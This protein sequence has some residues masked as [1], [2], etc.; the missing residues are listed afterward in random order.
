M[1]RKNSILLVCILLIFGTFLPWGNTMASSGSIVIATDMVNVRSGPGLSYSLVKQAKRGEKYPV[2][3]EKGDWVQIQLSTFKTGWVVSWLIAKENGESKTAVASSRNTKAKAITEQLRV[4]SGPGTS[5]QI[6]GLLA[7]GEE[8]QILDQNENWY[9]IDTQ[10]GE[11]WASKE[12]FNTSTKTNN[13]T[14]TSTT[15]LGRVNVDLLNVREEPSSKSTN[16][17]KLTK[18]T[19]VTI[20]S[21]KN[22][23]IEISYSQLTGWVS[24]EFI[25]KQSETAPVTTKKTTSDTVGTITADSL[26]VRSGTSYNSSIVGTVSNGESYP[27][28]EE[29]NGWT[30]IEYKPGNY[31]WVASWYINNKMSDKENGQASKASKITILQDGTNIRTSPDVQSDVMLRADEGE[32]FPVISVL[33]DWYLVKLDNGKTG[34]VAGWV[35]TTN[36][37]AKNIVKTGAAGYLKNKTIVLDPGHGGGD[38]G[39]TGAK[40]T[41]EKE[42]TLRTARLLYDKLVSAGANVYLTRNSDTFISLSSRVRAAQVNDADAFISLHYDSNLDRSVRGMTGYFYHSFQKPLANTVY[43]ATVGQTKMK[44]RGVRF[45]DFHVIRENNKNATL[46]ELGYL[47]NPE[48]EMT[49]TSSSFQ[50]SAAT[51][52]FEGLARYFKQ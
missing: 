16:L 5:F 10:F 32:Q 39:T 25:T 49:L 11:G 21:E 19:N 8:V 26:N 29:K 33:N 44:N 2:I 20:L 48:E 37:S 51:G 12:F 15:N 9:K 14:E 6:I 45:G 36:G 18:G 13:K 27:I 41:L 31:G 17:G 52:L 1:F 42:L 3:K 23:W 46:I 50:E 4:R 7:K 24:S 30:K 43:T 40:G 34:Y 35:V 38:N 22:N 47:S 28:M